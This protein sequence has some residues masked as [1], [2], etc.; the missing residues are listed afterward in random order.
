M[1]LC[2]CV[3][4]YQQEFC[5][6]TSIESFGE[7]ATNLEQLS[8]VALKLYLLSLAPILLQ[9]KCRLYMSLF[10]NNARYLHFYCVV[11]F[12]AERQTRAVT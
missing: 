7:I 9:M 5:Q 8:V 4:V 3:S 1:Q 12:S 2:V 11:I 6:Q 10:C